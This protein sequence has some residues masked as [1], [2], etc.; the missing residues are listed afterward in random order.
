[1]ANNTNVNS[2]TC[3]HCGTKN[4]AGSRACAGC[5]ITFEIASVDVAVGA[6]TE[7]EQ[8]TQKTPAI[9]GVAL[10]GRT[11][12]EHRTEVEEDRK[13]VPTFQQH[14]AVQPG[15]VH[16]EKPQHA[17]E[18]PVGAPSIRIGYDKDNDLVIPLPQVSG[19]HAELA[20]VGERFVL[21]D[22][23]STN[24]VYV[25]GH[26]IERAYV[27][28]GENIG[29]G[30]YEFPLSKQI[31][32]KLEA[33]EAVPLATQAISMPESFG[34]VL[35]IGRDPDCDIVLDAPRF[36]ANTLSCNGPDAVGASKTWGR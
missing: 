21:K 1:M 27:R 7:P 15:T 34:K 12:V 18:I 23:G 29:L 36:L 6:D 33:V 16:G 13:R 5:S 3:P 35:V 10:E 9:V 4:P 32:E 11:E 31:T 8:K 14:K 20:Q 24:G 22:L 28:M 30:S 17:P 19:R 2:V 25:N 26:R